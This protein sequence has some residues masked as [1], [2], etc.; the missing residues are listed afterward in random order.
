MVSG[1]FVLVWSYADRDCDHPPHIHLPTYQPSYLEYRR[2]TA[3]SLVMQLLYRRPALEP[4]M[5][6][7]AYNIMQAYPPCTRVMHATTAFEG[8]NTM[9][10]CHCQASLTASYCSLHRVQVACQLAVRALVSL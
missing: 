5:A 7:R 2:G 6:L 1:A 3:W 9:N 8:R 4:C 10:Q